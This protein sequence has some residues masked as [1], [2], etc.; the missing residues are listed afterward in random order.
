MAS[1]TPL[2][3]VMDDMTECWT[4]LH[5]VLLMVVLGKLLVL[6]F[7]HSMV[8]ANKLPKGVLLT[9]NC[10]MNALLAFVALVVIDPFCLL[11]DL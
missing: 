1:M 9:L 6:F 7:G 3:N 10:S 4:G 2:D 11:I 8:F 5:L